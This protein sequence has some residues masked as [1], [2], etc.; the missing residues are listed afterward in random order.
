MLAEWQ[1]N[2]HGIS[3]GGCPAGRDQASGKPLD[4]TDFNFKGAAFD[5]YP[6]TTFQINTGCSPSAPYD[7][8]AVR[9]LIV[10]VLEVEGPAIRTWRQGGRSPAAVAPA[11]VIYLE[12]KVWTFSSP[13]AMACMLTGMSTEKILIFL[14]WRN[15]CFLGSF[16]MATVIICCV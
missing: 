4:T 9:T 15:S 1:D 8:L 11:S 10:P 13:M 5:A 6:D 14:S 2:K 3:V 7:N 12:L 16:S